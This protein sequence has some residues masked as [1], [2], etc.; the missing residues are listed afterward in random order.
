MAFWSKKK[1]DVAADVQRRDI[2]K[3]YIKLERERTKPQGRIAPQINVPK[4]KQSVQR[5]VIA[6]EGEKF[7]I[8]KL[9]KFIFVFLLI[10]IIIWVPLNLYLTGNLANIGVMASSFFSNVG[11][12]GG[13]FQVFRDVA[14]LVTDPT[15]SFANP[16]D[17][18]IPESKVENERRGVRVSNLQ[19]FGLFEENEPIIVSGVVTIENME[20]ANL[21]IACGL[22]GYKGEVVT[23]VLEDDKEGP[24]VNLRLR[25]VF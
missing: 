12:K 8:G 9:I 4:A 7:T 5:V 20:E 6:R 14:K 22:D 21:K 25:D 2:L 24:F 11:L 1:D 10:A 3:D 16:W 23:R 19:S 17:T 13:F 15:H 18:G